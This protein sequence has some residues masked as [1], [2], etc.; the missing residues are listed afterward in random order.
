MISRLPLGPESARQPR[1][2][3]RRGDTRVVLLGPSHGKTSLAFP[4]QCR[5]LLLYKTFK[6]WF[7]SLFIFSPQ[8]HRRTDESR[9][10]LSPYALEP[11]SL[12][13][14]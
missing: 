9:F 12:I 5:P 13:H 3:L 1:R 2:S 10:A 6:L 11:L 4:V 8:Q 14:I 7:H